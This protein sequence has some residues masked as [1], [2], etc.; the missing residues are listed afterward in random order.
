MKIKNILM[1]ALAALTIVPIGALAATSY[2]ATTTMYFNIPSDA[3]FSIAMPADYTSFTAITGTS[4]GAATATSW[5]SFNT[6]T[7]PQA[8]LQQATQL[9]DFA[10]NQ[11]GSLVPIFYI[12]NT[13][14]TN[15]KFEIKAAGALPTGVFVWFNA[16]GGGTPTTTLTALTVGYQTLE[17][18]MTNAQFLNV[19]LYANTSAASATGQTTQSLYI[20]STAV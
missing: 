14:N 13:G 5:I 6:T 20:K 10:K 11:T 3:S 12:D 18:S 4:E 15:E 8:T 17:A 19:T 9:G 2:F 16:T 1:Y 7:W